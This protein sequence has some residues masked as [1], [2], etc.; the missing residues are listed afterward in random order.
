LGLTSKQIITKERLLEDSVYLKFACVW[1]TPEAPGPLGKERSHCSFC[2]TALREIR[3]PTGLSVNI[4]FSLWNREHPV[5][6][7]GSYT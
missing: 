3:S 4:P 7:L 2:A 6:L 1:E 5:L